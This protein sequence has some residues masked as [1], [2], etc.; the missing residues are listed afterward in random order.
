MANADAL[1]AAPPDLSLT[2][3]LERAGLLATLGIAGALQVSIAAAQ[4]LLAVAAL[5][6]LALIVLRHE[7]FDVPRFF[8]PLAGLAGLTLVS[9]AFSPD[10]RTS[11]V[12]TK[13]LL[14]F[15][16]VPLVLPLRER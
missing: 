10:P 5:C 13:Q 3:R 8:W 2:T 14:L 12:D 15:L 11:F 16:M 6:W 9:A 1:S 4:A 7:R